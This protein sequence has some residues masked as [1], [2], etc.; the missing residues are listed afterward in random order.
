MRQDMAELSPA[1]ERKKIFL[2]IKRAF[3]TPGR[4]T[5]YRCG[6]P[7][8]QH[9]IQQIGIRRRN[10]LLD[11]LAVRGVLLAASVPT[12]VIGSLAGAY[13]DRWEKRRTMLRAVALC[14][15][16]IGML[17]LFVLTGSIEHPTWFLLTMSSLIV[18]LTTSCSPFVGPARL[19]APVICLLSSRAQPGYSKSRW[20]W[21]WSL[22]FC[23]PPRSISARVRTVPFD[24]WALVCCFMYRDFSPGWSRHCPWQVRT[25]SN[26]AR[27]PRWNPSF[28]RQYRPDHAF[29]GDRSGDA[30]SRS[31][32]GSGYL[33]RHAESPHPAGLLWSAQYGAGGRSLLVLS[34]G[35]YA[36][37]TRRSC[38]G[39][40]PRG[41]N[42]RREKKK[43]GKRKD[44]PS[45]G[46]DRHSRPICVNQG[47]HQCQSRSRRAKKSS[48]CHCPHDWEMCGRRRS[49]P[50]CQSLSRSRLA[51]TRCCNGHEQVI[52]PEMY[53]EG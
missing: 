37:F 48:R 9:R 21:L 33:L 25:S 13:V 20:A 15:V 10:G 14:T 34:A 5:R 41:A 53:C 11:P 47:E 45:L 36:T 19:A 46:E 27:V 44:Q 31:Y 49:C 24:R 38:Q 3:A 51:C 43:E 26:T 17:F 2:L 8:H 23:R 18:L 39:T 7:E 22:V 29:P 32:A 30:G 42:V 6:N 12:A 50:N 52:G 35:I 4:V 28:Y 40:P 1:R 16:L